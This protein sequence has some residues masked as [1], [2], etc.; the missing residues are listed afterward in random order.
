MRKP[1]L[2]VLVFAGAC[3]GL[4]AQGRE[5]EP[6]CRMCPGTVIA[7]SEID[8]YLKRAVANHITD[9]QVRAVD[10]GKSHIGIGA[11]Y[12]PKQATAEAVA[13][14]DLVSEVYHII[15]GRATLTL[16]PDLVGKERRPASQKTVRVQNGPGNGAKEIRNGVSYD[17]APG[18]VVII[19]A[20]T[21]HQFRKID[22]DISYLMVRFDPE[23]IVP[24]KSEAESKADLLGTGIETPEEA[25]AAGLKNAHL[26]KEYAPNC[27][28]CPGYYVPRSEIDAY[29]KRAIANQLTDQQIRAVNIGKMNVGIGVV[30]RGRLANPEASVAEHDLVSEIY[31]V[32]DG[33]A[34]LNLGPDLV[35]KVRRPETL[36]TVRLLNGPGNGATAIRNGTSYQI[37][38]GDVVTIPAGTGHQFTR[39]DDHITYLMVRVDPDKV[40]PLKSEADSKADLA[41]DGRATAGGGAGAVNGVPQR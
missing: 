23:K 33:S 10:V 18:D 26:E 17:L 5:Y 12:R 39:I 13:E 19:P 11:V 30:Y 20:G 24:V 21:G 36:T 3:L 35:G 22:E 27:Q 16:G 14:H 15:Q 25:R 1:V 31:H 40:L 8:A 6:T 38:A 9:Q 4:A 29:T 34:T 2:G 37:K 28:M 7:K 32:I 41:T